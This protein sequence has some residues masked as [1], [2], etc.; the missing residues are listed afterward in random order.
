MTCGSMKVAFSAVEPHTM[1]QM[2]KMLHWLVPDP[3]TAVDKA[4]TG[5]SSDSSASEVC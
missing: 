5:F 1:G 3:P 4:P 2:E